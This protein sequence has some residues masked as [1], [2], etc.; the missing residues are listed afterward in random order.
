[1]TRFVAMHITANKAFGGDV[2]VCLVIFSRQMHREKLV[3]FADKL[4]LA[5]HQFHDAS[6]VV[7]HMK[8]EIP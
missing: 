7:R 5:S 6:H 3:E 4:L 2:F 8:R 1:M